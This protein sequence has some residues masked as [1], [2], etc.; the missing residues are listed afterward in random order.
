M[1]NTK[2]INTIG[3]TLEGLYGEDLSVI[4]K[5]SF[6]DFKKESNWKQ[7]VY[8]LLIS[9]EDAN[10]NY[11]ISK[12]KC[13]TGIHKMNLSNLDDVLRAINYEIDPSQTEFY[14]SEE[15]FMQFYNEQFGNM[16]QEEDLFETKVGSFNLG[17]LSEYIKL[18]GSLFDRLMSLET[19]ILNNQSNG[20]FIKS[21]EY[22]IK[23][24]MESITH[25]IVLAISKCYVKGYMKD[26]V[27]DTSDLEKYSKYKTPEPVIHEEVYLLDDVID[28]II[29]TSATDVVEEPKV[30]QQQPKTVDSGARK[31]KVERPKPE[32]KAPEET[33]V[34]ENPKLQHPDIKVTHNPDAV[35]TKVIKGNNKNQANPNP[36]KKKET[37]QNVKK[38]IVATDFLMS[39]ND[40]INIL[41]TINHINNN[42]EATLAANWNLISNVMVTNAQLVAD[43]NAVW[44]NTVANI[45]DM[46]T[47]CN[48]PII[49]DVFKDSN[50][51]LEAQIYN[52]ISCIVNRQNMVMYIISQINQNET[53]QDTILRT[54]YSYIMDSFNKLTASINCY[55]IARGTD[56]NEIK[57]EEI[58]K[59]V[60]SIIPTPIDANIVT[61]NN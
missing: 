36:E 29:N 45:V 37:P 39:Q 34:T 19:L 15:E 11:G 60:N 2:Q 48:M 8:H 40:K 26:I 31:I 14:F 6:Y 21:D 44:G 56:V 1:T 24:I 53:I 18:D 43:V 61:K 20:I 46:N 23:D 58:V 27:L 10:S 57:V 3:M 16:T 22:T 55:M 50:L 25:S 28:G 5:G 12:S 7:C 47:K 13:I 54:F 41:N 38:G 17:K 4:T 33:K 42:I 51:Q 59:K 35:N 52:A 9:L 32:E 49:E 30:V